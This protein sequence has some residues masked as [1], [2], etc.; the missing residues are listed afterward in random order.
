MTAGKL[1]DVETLVGLLVAAAG[2]VAVAVR[3]VVVPGP[4]GLRPRAEQRRGH[5]HHRDELAQ[6]TSPSMSTD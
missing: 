1:S 6:V 2:L 5:D 3:V 4:G